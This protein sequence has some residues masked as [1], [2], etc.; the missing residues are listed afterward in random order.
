MPVDC[1]SGNAGEQKR[2]RTMART[3]RSTAEGVKTAAPRRITVRAKSGST[4]PTEDQIRARAYEIYLRRNGEPGDPA[5]DWAQAERELREE[6]SAR[7]GR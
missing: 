3:T 1:D 6:L 4:G 7:P 2:D 5:A